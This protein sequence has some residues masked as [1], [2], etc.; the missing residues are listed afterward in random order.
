ML[1]MNSF[2]YICMNITN[3]DEHCFFLNF[4]LVFPNNDEHCI[5]LI[6]F[7]YMYFCVSFSNKLLFKFK[8]C[9]ILGL[10]VTSD[11]LPTM[12]LLYFNYST[13]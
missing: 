11:V 6:E 7:I 5:F 4:A 9:V 3:N 10:C 2:G 13:I 8:Q 1:M 12:P